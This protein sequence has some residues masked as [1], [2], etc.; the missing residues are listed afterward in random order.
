MKYS[1]T[2]L[3]IILMLV[4]FFGVL[5][6]DNYSLF[7]SKFT[8]TDIQNDKMYYTDDVSYHLFET[9]NGENIITI[10]FV[11]KKTGDSVK[12][13]HFIIEDRTGDDK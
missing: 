7:T 13:N 2:T 10:Y 11:D 4:I 12:L 5:A 1:S 6:C 9:S 3:S 8:V